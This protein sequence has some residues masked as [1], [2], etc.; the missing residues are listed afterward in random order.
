[1]RISKPNH[2]DAENLR[3][4]FARLRGS[5]IASF[6]EAEFAMGDLLSAMERSGHFDDVRFHYPIG[7]RLKAFRKVCLENAADDK[8]IERIEW[9]TKSFESVID[10][11]NSLAHGAAELFPE[12]RIVEVLK[13]TPATGDKHS[14]LKATYDLDT[15]E[16]NVREFDLISRNIIALSWSLAIS[17]GLVENN[18]LPSRIY[19]AEKQ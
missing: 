6:S 11:R 7:K 4:F 10:D 18:N 9:A 2:P 17:L 15:M 14:I 13:F 16:N 8:I 12:K 19:L 1:M 3:V 5:A